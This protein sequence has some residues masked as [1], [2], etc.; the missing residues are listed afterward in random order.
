[1]IRTEWENPEKTFIIWK[2]TA[3]WMF[4]EFHAAEKQVNMM[5]DSVEGLVDSI[6]IPS[7]GQPIPANSL[8]H[9]QTLITHKHKRHGYIVIVGARVFVATLLN[10]LC[11]LVPGM[12]IHLR[13]A[14]SQTE[15]QQI[16]VS[17]R[18]KHP[19]STSQL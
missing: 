2:F 18:Q 14:K 7:S 15:V 16:L 17:L 5:I 10:T 6:F 11:E 8:R 9:P 4:G 13:V 3:P 19:Q 12:G 1:M